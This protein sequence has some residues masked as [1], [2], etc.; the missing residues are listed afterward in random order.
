[1]SVEIYVDGACSGNPGVG[2]YGCI[3]KNNG[4][5]TEFS[6]AEANATNNRMEV[7]GAIVALESLKSHSL[8]IEVFSDSQYLVKGMNGWVYDWIKNGWRNSKRQPTPNKDLWLRLLGLVK[9]H[10]IIWTWVKAHNGHP[11]NER[12]DQLAKE[13]MK[14]QS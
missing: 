5:E 12:C 9:K 3:I 1:M 11:E 4:K 10:R 2:G 14:C 7:L 8:Q 6:G 13:A